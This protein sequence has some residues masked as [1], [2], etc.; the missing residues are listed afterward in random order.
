MDIDNVI[1]LPQDEQD[2]IA[3]EEAL[4]QLE[5][6]IPS[7]ELN[8][9]EVV[10]T[11][12]VVAPE[13]DA[14]GGQAVPPKGAGFY[15]INRKLAISQDYMSEFEVEYIKNGNCFKTRQEA[16]STLAL[17]STYFTPIEFR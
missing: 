14:W 3:E 9:D 17:I 10:T 12:G 1:D 15:Y 4:S 7:E 16:E 2:K 8:T 11:N 6:E 13:A 5:A